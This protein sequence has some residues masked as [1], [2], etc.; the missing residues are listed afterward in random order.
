M[1]ARTARLL[2]RPGWA[3]DA[4][5]L[6]AAIADPAIVRNLTRA[7]WPYSEED[8]RAYLEAPQPGPLPDF[9]IVKRTRGAP[10]LIGGCGISAREDGTPELGYWIARRYWGLGF[11]TEAASAVMH[12]ARATGLTGIRASH[13]L[14][15]P[16][17]AAVLRKLGFRAT[18]RT[19]RRHSAARGEAAECALFEDADMRPKRPDPSLELY[20]DHAAIAA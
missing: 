7:P 17:S 2:L 13:F 4:P 12:I 19:E 10:Q 8:A 5:A 3:E 20:R 16:A 14:D 18:G 15:N 11:A 9:L 6:A 1:F